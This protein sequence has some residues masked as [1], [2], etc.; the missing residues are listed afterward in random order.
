MRNYIVKFHNGYEME[1]VLFQTA[2]LD[3]KENRNAKDV[4]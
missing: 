1:R 3:E 4:E 2:S